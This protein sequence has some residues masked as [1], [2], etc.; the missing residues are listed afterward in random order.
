MKL[1]IFDRV[2]EI[3][4]LEDSKNLVEDIFFNEE[5]VF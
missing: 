3:E 2:D 1:K 4:A 5:T